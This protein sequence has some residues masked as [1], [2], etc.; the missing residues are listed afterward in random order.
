MTPPA[1]SNLKNHVER[2]ESS[3]HNYSAMSGPVEA[4]FKA[5]A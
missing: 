1:G 2:P 5:L 4:F 3:N